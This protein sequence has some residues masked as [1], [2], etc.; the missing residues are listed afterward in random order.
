M[1]C[2]MNVYNYKSPSPCVTQSYLYHT[3]CVK[4]RN[5]NKDRMVCKKIQLVLSDFI[6][7]FLLFQS[8][9]LHINLFSHYRV[10]KSIYTILCCCLHKL[11]F[12]LM[13]NLRAYVLLLKILFE[14]SFGAILQQYSCNMSVL[15]CLFAGFD[16]WDPFKSKYDSAL[17]FHTATQIPSM[18]TL[19]LWKK[20]C[21]CHF[22]VDLEGRESGSPDPN[23][24]PQRNIFIVDHCSLILIFYYYI[25]GYSPSNTFF[26]SHHFGHTFGDSTLLVQASFYKLFCKYSAGYLT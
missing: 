11:V 2:D 13:Y 18:T 7:D 9:C 1:L 17:K 19:Q 15:Y 24:S 22:I 25:L 5:M 3:L 10:F 26:A 23:S 20:S 16:Y 14:C 21:F 4:R 8:M 12:Y 6:T